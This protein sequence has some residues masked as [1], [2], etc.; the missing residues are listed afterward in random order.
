MGVVLAAYQ[1]RVAQGA[2]TQDP[3]Q[4]KAIA[5]LDAVHGALSAY[6]DAR[7]SLL[8]RVLGKAPDA[9]RGLYLWGG[10]GRGKT[11]LMDLFF[12]LCPEGLK[13]RRAHFHEFMADVHDRIRAARQ[14]QP[15][16]PMPIV[17]AEIAREARLLCFD[18][19]HVTDIADAMILGR[20]FEHLFAAGV[21]VVAT[22]NV[23]PD[24]LY[25]NG[26]NRALF[27]PFIKLL[28]DRLA[29]L[30][31]VSDT[32]H[33]LRKLAGHQLYFTPLG[34]EADAGMDS[35]WRDVVGPDGGEA[36]SLHV[37][38]RTI[39]VPRQAAGAA[40]FSF[41]QLCEAPLGARDYLAIARA[42]H[43]VFIDHVP[44]MA[45]ADRNAARRF[46]NLIDT[47]YDNRVCLA[48]SADAAPDDLYIAGDGAML[49][50]RTA[51]RLIEMRS[52]AYVADRLAKHDHVE[53]QAGDA[54]ALG[55]FQN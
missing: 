19:F 38:G 31:L 18:E 25:E 14:S 2:L 16:D 13:K 41:A 21:V 34:G 43:T 5:A 28:K 12:E 4:A 48:V 47:L 40:R 37:S 39:H 9:P 17:A 27:V 51:S 26:L 22:S 35:L 11:M 30:E 44:V 52:R 10:V 23:P 20:L 54:E 32:D 36:A 45:P 24:R 6:R 8:S 3:A 49:F 50:E 42:Y 55:L 46:I 53:G 1:A 15:G 7:R 33:R 29:E